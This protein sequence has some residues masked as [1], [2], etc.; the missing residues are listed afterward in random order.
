MSSSGAKQTKHI[1]VTGG[2]VSSLG[3]GLTC[4][5][6]GMLLE[7]LGRPDEAARV[8]RAV[9]ADLSSRGSAVRSTSEVG[10]AIASLL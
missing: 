5:S 4:A 9:V 6:I 7:H 1:F 10:D 3:K 2:V 8:E